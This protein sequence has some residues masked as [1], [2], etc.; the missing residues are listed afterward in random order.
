MFLDRWSARRSTGLGAIWMFA[1]SRMESAVLRGRDAGRADRATR[2]RAGRDRARFVAHR[3]ESAE[4]VCGISTSRRR[5]LLR[6]G[7][8]LRAL[9]ALCIWDWERAMTAPLRLP[10]HLLVVRLTPKH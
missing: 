4:R 3:F 10:L 6:S 7:R 5:S 8:G 9:R 1:P 2:G